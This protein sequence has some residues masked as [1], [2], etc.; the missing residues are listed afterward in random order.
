MDTQ[1]EEYGA[2][3][4]NT[5]DGVATTCGALIR[6]FVLTVCLAND[7]VLI[8]VLGHHYSNDDGDDD[9]IKLLQHCQCTVLLS[10]NGL[11]GLMESHPAV[12]YK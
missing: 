6:L 1:A 5:K 2:A 9:L 8:L 11:A 10:L 12:D 7:P 4:S 3:A